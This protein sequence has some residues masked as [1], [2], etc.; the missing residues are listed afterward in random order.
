MFELLSQLF[1]Q[2]LSLQM[3]IPPQHSQV[4]VPG[5]TGDF[6]NIQSLLEQPG[7]S[8]VAQVVESQVID[9]STMYRTDVGTFDGLDGARPLLGQS[10]DLKGFGLQGLAL[11]PDL[12]L[13]LIGA[14]FSEGCHSHTPL[15]RGRV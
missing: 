3:R 2:I 15:V 9:A 7:S 13:L 5:D 12:R 14:A 8:L 1:R 11:F 10:T 6:H 4:L